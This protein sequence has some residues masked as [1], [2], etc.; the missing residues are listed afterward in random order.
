MVDGDLFQVKW[1]T[2]QSWMLQIANCAITV[3]DLGIELIESTDRR[4]DYQN[5]YR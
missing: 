2:I 3:R 5:Y 4:T 1:M